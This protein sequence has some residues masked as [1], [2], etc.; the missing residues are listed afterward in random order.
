MEDEF[1]IIASSHCCGCKIKLTDNNR[2]EWGPNFW[3]QICDK[4][5]V[6]RI[7]KNLENMFTQFEL[8]NKGEL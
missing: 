6:D 2:G 1:K 7:T 5:R 3:C 8:R 4:E